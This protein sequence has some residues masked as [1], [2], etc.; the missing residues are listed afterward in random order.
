[1][2][3]CYGVRLFADSLNKERVEQI[4]AA[5]HS[6]WEFEQSE[7]LFFMGPQKNICLLAKSNGEPSEM[8]S[9]VE[10]SSRIAQAVWKANGRYCPVR[11]RIAEEA[12]VRDFCEQ[13]YRQFM[14]CRK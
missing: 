1:M 11:I 10:F 13:E 8:E 6:E 3:V 9:Q 2:S 5:V 12:N 4:R 14:R 7:V